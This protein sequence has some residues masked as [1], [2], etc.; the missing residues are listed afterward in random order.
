VN[1]SPAPV[2]PLPGLEGYGFAE[3]QIEQRD[4]PFLGD[5]R[6]HH[7]GSFDRGDAKAPVR[8][9]VVFDSQPG[10][11][12]WGLPEIGKDNFEMGDLGTRILWLTLPQPGARKVSFHFGSDMPARLAQV[13]VAS[14]ESAALPWPPPKPAPDTWRREPARF[15][16]RGPSAAEGGWSMHLKL[17]FP[18]RQ[19]PA[20]FLVGCS[21]RR[22]ELEVMEASDSPRGAGCLAQPGP[23]GNS[24]IVS[25]RP[26]SRVNYDHISLRLMCHEPFR[27]EKVERLFRP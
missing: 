25:V 20:E 4:R 6:F 23:D 9:I 27:V 1:A 2:L 14:D 12:S 24:L 8:L 16:V 11:L 22:D 10:P 18:D 26:T 15:S 17:E 5:G 13:L 21:C 19:L 7:W 3:L